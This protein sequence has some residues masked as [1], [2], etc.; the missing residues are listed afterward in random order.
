MS[1]SSRIV[2]GDSPEAVAYALLIG[3]A[4][5]EDKVTSWADFPVPQAD[6]EW[7]LVTYVDCLR[8]AKGLE[9]K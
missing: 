2:S 6:K 1:D 3:I 9:A 7:V 4:S 8:A 5:A